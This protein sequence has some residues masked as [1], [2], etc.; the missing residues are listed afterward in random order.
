MSSP[1][2]QPLRPTRAAISRILATLLCAAAI[3]CGLAACT[4]VV[5]LQPAKD[6]VDPLCASVIVALRQYPTVA[7][8]P[9]RQTDA[10]GTAAWGDPA[11]VILHCGVTPPGPTASQ[12]CR[13]FEGVDWLIDDS[14]NPIVVATTYGR[15]PAIEVVIETDAQGVV[16]SDLAPAIAPLPVDRSCVGIGPA[17]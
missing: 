4:P 7:D 17:G 10:Q 12:Q 15:T 5:S 16:L 9:A 1:R 8:L 11:A 3:S 13:T 6:A 14:R 2:A